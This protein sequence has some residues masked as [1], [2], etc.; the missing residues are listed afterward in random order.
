MSSIVVCSF[1]TD[2]EYYR[3]EAKAL[4]AD[5]DKLGVDY[6]LDEIAKKPGQ[7]WADL[8]RQKVPFLQSVC[9][10]FPD[11]KVFWIDV[12]CRLLSLPDYIRN[13][14]ADIIGFQRGFGSS[15]TIG[16][17]NRT[18]FWEPCFW[19]VGTSVNARKM[20]SDAAEVE[21]LFAV[22]VAQPEY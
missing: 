1:Y 16:Y 3:N 2:D 4:K 17:Q 20:I 8:C 7:D 13:S 12:D 10:R 21:R 15:L 6:V 19:G 5:L 14:S 11:K 9:E 22:L 18:R